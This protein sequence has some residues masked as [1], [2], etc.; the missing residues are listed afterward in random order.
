LIALARHSARKQKHIDGE[1]ALEIG[2]LLL[3]YQLMK[4]D[5]IDIQKLKRHTSTQT[6]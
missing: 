5:I 6:G 4:L 2:L 1:Y 3:P